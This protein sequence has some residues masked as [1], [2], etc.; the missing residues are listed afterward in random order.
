MNLHFE[1]PRWRVESQLKRSWPRAETWLQK[2]R[3]L[4]RSHSLLKKEPGLDGPPWLFGRIHFGTK[5]RVGW[6]Q[7]GDC[8]FYWG[9][10]WTKSRR[11]HQAFEVMKW[12]LLGQFPMKSTSMKRICLLQRQRISGWPQCVVK[13]PIEALKPCKKRSRSCLRRVLCFC[14]I[15]LWDFAK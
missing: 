10:F 14:I 2:A 5:V 7:K 6:F 8:L 4:W 12:P 11:V 1:S 9:W 3:Q 13:T 15:L